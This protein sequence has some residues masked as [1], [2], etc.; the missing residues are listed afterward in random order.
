MGYL[1]V[2]TMFAMF[3]EQRSFN[4]PIGEWDT[5]K[6]TDMHGLVVCCEFA[7]RIGAGI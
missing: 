6:V 4:Q 7:P 2:T 5:S 3:Y 1:K